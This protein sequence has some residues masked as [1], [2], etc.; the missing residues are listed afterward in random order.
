[1]WLFQRLFTFVGTL[2]QISVTDPAVFQEVWS[3]LYR[4]SRALPLGRRAYRPFPWRP[5]C[6][7]LYTAFQGPSDEEHS[8]TF[9]FGEQKYVIKPC[10]ITHF[11]SDKRNMLLSSAKFLLKNRMAKPYPLSEARVA[12]SPFKN[13]ARTRKALAAYK[14]KK[15]VGF[16]A[17]S[18]LKSMGLVPRAN[19]TYTLGK[20]YA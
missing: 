3:R 5:V 10:S 6:P 2:A 14:A 4:A 19:G 17:T 9:L 1:M 16:T 12:K 11:C 20:K 8:L 7:F 18:S 13:M 15:S